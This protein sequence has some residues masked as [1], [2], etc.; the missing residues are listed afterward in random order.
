[1]HLSR[2]VEN[3]KPYPFARMA[4][5]LAALKARGVD[6]I[7]MDIGSPDML[8]AEHILAAA[9]KAVRDT[10]TH[11]YPA[12]GY[13]TPS[14]LAAVAEYYGSRFDVAL[15]PKR[16]ITALLG[17]KEGIFHLTQALL[18]EGD[19]ALVPDPGYPVY[20]VAAEWA[21]AEVYPL[22][23]RREKAFLP[24]LDSIPPEIL[25][26]ARILW[27]NY[28]NNPTAA[29]AGRDFYERAIELARRHHILLC[30]DAAYCGVA[31]DGYRPVSIL[32]PAGAREYAVEFSSVSKTY[33]MA[34]W[35]LGFVSGN[36][37]AVLAVRK[38]KSNI[39]SGIFPAITAAGEAALRGD[40]DWLAARNAVYAGRRDRILSG[41]ADIGIKCDSPRASLY[42]WAPVP[43]G[44]TAESF[45][46]SVLDQTG[47]C[48][49][50]G[51][52]FGGEGEGYVRIS[53]A[54]PNE[55]VKE[56]MRRLKQWKSS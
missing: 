12:F 30:H 39:D 20:R 14:L 46:D 29:V 54:T 11:G 51:T 26:R 32:E 43:K 1:M 48:F 52:F 22:P 4:E 8:P 35:R 36:A 42:I 38:V 50:P 33:N 45:A 9:E 41:L 24:D 16:E 6:V 5:K 2:R 34:G 37:E 31:Y 21:R 49:A 40:Q 53:L 56:A 27:L 44:F 23:L 25:R 55:R 18:Q 7:R 47:V 28:P 13:G 15:D 19:I 10:G 3:L 17:S